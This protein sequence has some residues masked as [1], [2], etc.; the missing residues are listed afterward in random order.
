MGRAAALMREYEVDIP[1]DENNAAPAPA[2]YV[3][4]PRRFARAE[5]W[6]G[7]LAIA[8]RDSFG[9]FV[10]R[11]PSVG[12]K[13]YGPAH[14]VSAACYAFDTLAENL[15][16]A[17]FGQPRAARRAFLAGAAQAIADRMKA[18]REASNL[19]ALAHKRPPGRQFT[20]GRRITIN[21][22]GSRSAGYAAGQGIGIRPGVADH[23]RRL[24]A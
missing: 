10:Y 2:E 18:E 3:E 8:I 11:T 4:E 5:P 1:R 17:A 12:L 15:R 16:A 21:D 14:R 24:T 6:H 20:A 23:R 22:D 13:F 9:V 19:P 7:I